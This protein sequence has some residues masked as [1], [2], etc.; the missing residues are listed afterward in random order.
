MKKTLLVLFIAIFAIS[1]QTKAQLGFKLG[2][3]FAKQS[4]TDA[5]G[6]SEKSLNN[7]ILGAFYEKDLIP[8][9]GLRIGAEYS[10]KGTK[11]EGGGFY[12]QAKINYLE[13][14]IQAKVKLGP[15]YALGGVYGAYALGG[16]YES[17]IPGQED[18]DIKFDKDYK[19]LDY[20]MKFGAGFQ[21]G[22]GPL[23]VFAQGEYSFGLADINDSGAGD[24]IKNS[25]ICVSAG[26]VLGF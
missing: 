4:G 10:P 7:L 2:Y 1:Y 22:L 11:F 12:T 23:H 14:P 25:V 5:P 26:V 18:S 20:G 17:D 16:K 24:A 13:I 9:L 6:M 21:T 3:N 8:L 19:R 15:V